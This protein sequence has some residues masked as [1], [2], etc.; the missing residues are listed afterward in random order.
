MKKRVFI[1]S[2]TI[3]ISHSTLKQ[4]FKALL[5][6]CL[7]IISV[8]LSVWILAPLFNLHLLPLNA[9][10]NKTPFYIIYTTPPKNDL[11]AANEL[12]GN[13]SVRGAGG[14]VFTLN[15][16]YY[17][18]ITIAN[19]LEKAQTITQNLQE[20][21]LNAKIYTKT[22]HINTNNLTKTQKQNLQKLYC[23]NINT[24]NNILNLIDDLNK[25]TINNNDANI[26]IFNIYTEYKT[27]LTNLN[28]LDEKLNYYIQKE[29]KIESLLFLLSQEQKENTAIS[30]T[31]KIR[32]YLFKIIDCL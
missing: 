22:I 14:N 21:Q 9:P 18:A 28:C 1:Y 29:I 11:D 25:K 30:F 15:N 4:K 3:L 31:S 5:Y 12:S 19:N 24:I 6:T 16:N 26:E 2:N 7:F 13:L 8:M 20:Q 17:V 23:T 10:T 32:N 27:M